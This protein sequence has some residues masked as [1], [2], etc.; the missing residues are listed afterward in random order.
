MKR[1]VSIIIVIFI[2]IGLFIGAGFSIYNYGL[3]K[4]NQEDNGVKKEEEFSAAGEEKIENFDFNAMEQDLKNVLATTDNKSYIATCSAPND[5][6]PVFESK[7]VKNSVFDD[8]MAK[9]RTSGS[10]TGDIAISNIDCPV[11]EIHYYI[12][13]SDTETVFEL[14]YAN[15][16]KVLLVKYKDNGY[17]FYYKNKSEIENF[18]SKLK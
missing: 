17:M 1:K 4:K 11:N 12:G 18:I 8:V 5:G 10:Y 3:N 9:L 14:Y 13:T 6:I 2:I 15:D 7:E 16:P